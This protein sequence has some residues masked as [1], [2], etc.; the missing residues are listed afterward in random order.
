MLVSGGDGYGGA[1][2]STERGG[3]LATKSFYRDELGTYGG[4]GGLPS[5]MY[6][7]PGS[8]SAQMPPAPFPGAFGGVG[9]ARP[10]TPDVGGS[11]KEVAVLRPGPAR[12]PVTSPGGW[13][14]PPPP[15]GFTGTPPP[16]LRGTPPMRG[17]P[18]E[19]ARQDAVGRSRPSW[20][21]SRGSRFAE[22]IG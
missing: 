11:E 21:G 9:A 15:S 19:S 6:A 16:G 22:N 5:S 14:T 7:A 3:E 13:G 10:R 12:M 8:S 1:G 4:P 20:D 17:S 2:P 18:G